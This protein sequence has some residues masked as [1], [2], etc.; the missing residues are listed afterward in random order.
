MLV[1]MMQITHLLALAD[2]YRRATGIEDKTLS[3]RVFGDSKKLAA[4]RGEADITTARF[5][6][7]VT[8]FASNWPDAAIWPST[9][10]R[11]RVAA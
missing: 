8:W 5:N 7:A 2:E 3:F 1:C 9:I 6:A 11:P 10:Q 4:L